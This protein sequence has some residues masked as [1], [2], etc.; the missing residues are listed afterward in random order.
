MSIDSVHWRKQLRRFGETIMEIISTR[1]SRPIATHCPPPK[2]PD[3]HGAKHGIMPQY[4]L[5][6]VVDHIPYHTLIFLAAANYS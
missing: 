4:I 6:A 5:S 2:V 3:G 1:P